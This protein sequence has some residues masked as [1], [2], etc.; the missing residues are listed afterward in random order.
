MF[1]LIINLKPFQ[2]FSLL[3]YVIL[4]V[5]FLRRPASFLS[6]GYIISLYSP[7]PAPTLN[8]VLELPPTY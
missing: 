5:V 6:P 4:G 8:C 2:I 1:E 3:G 7:P